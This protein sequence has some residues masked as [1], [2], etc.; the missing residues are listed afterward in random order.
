[1]D[2]VRAGL[3]SHADRYFAATGPPD[4]HSYQHAR[5]A[6]AA[7]DFIAGHQLQWP[8]TR[9]GNHWFERML[10]SVMRCGAF[11]LLMSFVESCGVAPSQGWSKGRSEAVHS[12]Y[13]FAARVANPGGL[14]GR[15]SARHHLSDMSAASTIDV[16]ASAAVA[17]WR[18]SLRMIAVGLTISADND[19]TL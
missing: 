13:R 4:S 1:M 9:V 14:S 3:V 15:P 19:I 10:L 18:T 17:N 8:C 2:V 12:G 11:M 7:S 5:L 16:S 6:G